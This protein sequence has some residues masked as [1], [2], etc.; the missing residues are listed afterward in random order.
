[1]SR[2]YIIEILRRQQSKPDPKKTLAQ[3]RRRIRRLG[4]RRTTSSGIR[5]WDMG[6]ILDGADYINL[7]YADP[8]NGT[9]LT[10]D[11]G[12]NSVIPTASPTI[13]DYT[14]RDDLIFAIDIADWKTNFRQINQSYIDRLGVSFTY[15]GEANVLQASDPR[16]DGDTWMPDGTESGTDTFL[17]SPE[18]TV[19]DISPATTHKFTTTRDYSATGVS[20]TQSEAMDIFMFPNFLYLG[21]NIQV[22]YSDIAGHQHAELLDWS[23][24]IA[25]RDVAL[26]TGHP[27]YGLFTRLF[28]SS[29]YANDWYGIDYIKTYHGFRAIAQDRSATGNPFVYSPLA[30]ADFAIAF[31]PTRFPPPP[32]TGPSLTGASFVQ[33]VIDAQQKPNVVGSLIAVIKQNGT[34]YYV[35]STE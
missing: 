10:Y 14:T 32:A 5:F 33:I 31:D 16:W 15:K 23:S 3:P 6:F 25:P 1:M 28:G 13:T 12:T 8:Q 7:P 20:F 29:T 9:P 18:L 2:E 26:D 17:N 34:Y 30:V 4:R 21:T 35:W 27:Y 19:L 24:I 11:A 22:N